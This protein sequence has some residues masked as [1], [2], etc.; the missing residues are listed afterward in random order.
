MLAARELQVP[1]Y[2]P[3][4]N[5][6]LRRLLKLGVPLGPNGLLTVR[7][8]RS[9]L[10]RTTPV[11]VVQRDGRRWVVGTFGDVNWVRNLREA[12]QA[13][14][15]VGGKKAA[16]TARELSQT[17]AGEFFETVLRPYVGDSA[18]KR[19]VLGALGASDII[20]DPGGAA[21]RRPVFEL[22]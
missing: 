4:L 17:E 1:R 2:V 14:V 6:V 22:R 18:L 3:I 5:P 12:R 16:V 9:G 8:R 15:A 19:L 7:G 21:L 11:A 10:M 13:V 20:A